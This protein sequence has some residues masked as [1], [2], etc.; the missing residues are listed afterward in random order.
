MV[1]SNADLFASLV[2]LLMACPAKGL[3]TAVILRSERL[4]CLQ[5][6]APSTL[7]GVIPYQGLDHGWA[8]VP[9]R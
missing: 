4:K 6:M 8:G 5:A 9:V 3:H 7:G 1:S 2:V